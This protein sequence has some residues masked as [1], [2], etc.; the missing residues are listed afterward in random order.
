[1]NEELESIIDKYSNILIFSGAGVSTLSGIRDYKN[2][3]LYWSN[4][5]QDYFT[6]QEIMSEDTFRKDKPL[7]F[8]YY[9]S[10]SE[11]LRDKKPNKCHYFAKELLEKG[12]L[13]GVITQNIDGLYNSLI[14]K[15]KLCEIH[16]S[17]FAY[18]CVK[19]GNTISEKQTYISKKGILH[20]YCCNFIAKPNVVLYGESF[21][22]ENQELYKSLMKKA[23]CILV[24]GTELDVVSHNMAIGD[25]NTFRVLINNKSVIL[26]KLQRF[27]YTNEISTLDWD[28]ELIGDFN[29]I[30]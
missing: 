27:G 28:R 29:T 25:S 6:H 24:M 9:Q 14:P 23:D 3:E 18:K 17:S 20:S 2:N 11:K 21:G 12:K 13:T 8:E 19:C 22:E 5:K 15:D 30:L 16:G 26:N 7:F 1:M 4:I 10:L